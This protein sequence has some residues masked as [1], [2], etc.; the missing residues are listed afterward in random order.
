[1]AKCDWLSNK[2]EM[3]RVNQ[4]IRLLDGR[5]LGFAE[6]GLTDGVPILYFHGWPSS[7]LEPRAVRDVCADMGFRMIAP[8]RPGF[9]L[10]DFRP[11]RTIPDFAEDVRQLAAHL[12]LER[13]AVLGV[14]GG[15]PYAAACAARMPEK[16]SAALLVCS[17]APADAPNATKGMVAVNR[18]LL[19]LA[20][21][22]PRLAQCVAGLCLW[23][24]W[25]KGEQVIPK[26]IEL[27]LPPADRLALSN[28]E[29]RNALTASSV[30]ALRDGVRAAVADG[31]LYSQPWGFSLQEIRAPVFLWH[32][33]MDVIVPPSMGHY[34]AENIPS[35]RASFLPEDGHFS[36]PFTR[37][38]EILTA[39]IP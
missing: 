29:L 4:Q 20:R 36:L 27:R 26:Q 23:A 33:E 1:M 5:N 7:R 11:G 9:G 10:S 34:L 17:V 37:L 12:R 22:A 31:L 15:G 28:L 19:T 24:I 8:D 38:R 2:R 16:L 39:A 13:F 14:S 25:R 6:Y 3:D 21:R 32:G 18:W 35:C 30:E